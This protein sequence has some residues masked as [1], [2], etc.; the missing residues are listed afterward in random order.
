LPKA[1]AKDLRD[2]PQSVRDDTQ[3][4]LAEKIGDVL[5]AALTNGQA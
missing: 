4:I 1:N 5:G 3:V 2:L